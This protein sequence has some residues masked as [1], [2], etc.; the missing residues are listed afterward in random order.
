MFFFYYLKHREVESLLYLLEE[1][2]IEM[3]LM[4][5]E[6]N[7]IQLDHQYEKLIGRSSQLAD[8]EDQIL[9]DYRETVM[10]TS[11]KLIIQISKI[12]DDRAKEK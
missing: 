7:E 3:D 5:S 12:L 4:I 9:L 8:W 6:V 10:I 1:T 2:E 11:E